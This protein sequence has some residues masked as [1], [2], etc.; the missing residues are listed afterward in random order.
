M[1]GGA[2]PSWLALALAFLYEASILLW[3]CAII[4]T[5]KLPIASAF[6]VSCEMSRL[7]MKVGL[8]LP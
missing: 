8:C 6:V 4:R 5:Y 2:I 1:F 7:W 3:P